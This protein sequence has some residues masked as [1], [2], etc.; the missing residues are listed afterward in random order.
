M[1]SYPPEA[2]APNG[3]LWWKLR[4]WPNKPKQRFGTEPRLAA[5]LHFNT[6]VGGI[7]TLRRLRE[8]LSEPNRPNDH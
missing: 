2:R 4:S 5:Y 3:K 1:N 7:L 6:E 8:A